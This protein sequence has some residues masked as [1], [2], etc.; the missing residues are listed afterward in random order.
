MSS[1]PA[2]DLD[3]LLTEVVDGELSHVQQQHLAVLLRDNPVLQKKYRDYLLLDS[4]LR[5]EQ[6][7]VVPSPTPDSLRSK[8][9]FRFLAWLL[10][11][12]VLLAL[13]ISLMYHCLPQTERNRLPQFTG[14]SDIFCIGTSCVGSC[15]A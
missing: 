15:G 11:A 2:Q 12:C 7:A 10:A 1:D 4:L 14:G 13:G 3:Q 8:Q 6:P 5:W 9:H